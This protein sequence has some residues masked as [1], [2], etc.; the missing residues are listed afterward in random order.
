MAPISN[1]LALGGRDTRDGY[2]AERL[3]SSLVE[4]PT[5]K[6]TL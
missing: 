4:Y 5:L 2:N 1:E 3:A 6:K